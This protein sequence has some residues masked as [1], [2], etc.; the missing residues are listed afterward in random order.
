MD[1]SSFQP[2]L[3]NFLNYLP[4]IVSTIIAF[5]SENLYFGLIGST[6]TA[7][8]VAFISIRLSRKQLFNIL[9][10]KTPSISASIIEIQYPLLGYPITRIL[11]PV[12]SIIVSLY[13]YRYM[14]L[15][16]VGLQPKKLE[17]LQPL[18]ITLTL[19]CPKCGRNS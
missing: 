10:L 1:V 15:K 5:Y 11:D 16:K 18:K 7:F 12:T 3:N 2:F 6:L 17:P 8:L 19:R 14:Q 13:L 9:L 4:F